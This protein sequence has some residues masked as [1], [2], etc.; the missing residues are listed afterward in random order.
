MVDKVVDARI[1]LG[2]HFRDGMD[3]ARSIGREVADHV[4]DRWFVRD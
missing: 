2:F 3:D 1:W 4:T